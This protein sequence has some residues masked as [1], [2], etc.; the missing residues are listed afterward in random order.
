MVKIICKKDTKRLYKLFDQFFFS[1]FR[2]TKKNTYTVDSP[3]MSV[4]PESGRN[5]HPSI[6]TVWRLVLIC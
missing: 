4:D 1:F 2:N 6:A 3:C 5:T